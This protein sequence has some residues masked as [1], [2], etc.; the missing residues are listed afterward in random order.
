MN[1]DGFWTVQAVS[2]VDGLKHNIT[3]KIYKYL[4]YFEDWW[5]LVKSGETQFVYRV[6]WCPH[7][8]EYNIITSKVGFLRAARSES[9]RFPDKIQLDLRSETYECIEYSLAA[10]ERFFIFRRERPDGFTLRV[11]VKV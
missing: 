3:V 5:R 1:K 4:D 2:R 8:S 7:D 6:R 9:S 10:F 11:T